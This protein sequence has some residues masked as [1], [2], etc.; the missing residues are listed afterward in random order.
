MLD[1][2]SPN[3]DHM[4]PL[5][6]RT[7]W[8]AVLAELWQQATTRRFKDRDADVAEARRWFGSP[9]FAMVCALAGVDADDVFRA[10]TDAVQSGQQIPIA[11]MRV[12]A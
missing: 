11:Q 10:F 12:A 2:Q 4:D 5:A 9:D 7:L 3:L 6:C 8:C 1:C